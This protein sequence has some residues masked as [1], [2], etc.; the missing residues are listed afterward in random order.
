MLSSL[1][2]CVCVCV[3]A[4]CALSCMLNQVTVRLREVYL[5]PGEAHLR[6]GDIVAAQCC[7]R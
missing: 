6:R 1:L 4:F 7:T 3:C 5:M 2:E